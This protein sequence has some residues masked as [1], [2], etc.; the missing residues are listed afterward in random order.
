MPTLSRADAM[1]LAGRTSDSSW[2]RF[3]R[4]YGIKRLPSGR[5]RRRDIEAALKKESNGQRNQDQK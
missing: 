3:C 1:N 2:S 5:V 4:Q